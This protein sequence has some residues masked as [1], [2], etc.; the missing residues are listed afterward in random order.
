[1]FGSDN[2]LNLKY[3]T[4]EG[5][6]DYLPE[7]CMAKQ[8]IEKKIASAFASYGYKTIKTPAF[9]Y[10]DIYSQSAGDVSPQKLYKFFDA[11]GRILALRGDITTSIAR[12]MGTKY[13]DP[14]PARLC[15]VADAFRYDGA[16]SSLSSEFT[17][18]G[19]ELI[20]DGSCEADAEAIIVTINALLSAGLDEFQIDIGQ[21]EFFKGL[22]QQLGLDDE[23]FEKIR[24]MIDFKDSFSIAQV[25]EKY[26]A[27]KQIKELVCR[28]P[29]LFG[30]AEVLEEASAK[31]LNK[32]S[33]DAL[34]NLK[35]VYNIICSCG[36]EKYVSL[37]LGMLQ[38]IDYYT[39][40][41]F[42]GVTYDVG[43]SVC[44]G[45]RYDSLIAD[46]GKNMSAVGVA[47]GVN[48]VLSALVRQNKKI[49][50]PKIDAVMITKPD[51]AKAM[52]AANVLRKKGY[53]IENFYGD[54][55]DIK[56]ALSF[57][58]ERKISTVIASEG[59]ESIK[60]Y[61]LDGSEK[62][63]SLCDIKEGMTL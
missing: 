8:S 43:F 44:G 50:T 54:G 46:F 58:N 22:A 18:A 63:I 60:L 16:A 33:A 5:V 10:I 51:F 7:E 15:Y 38:S 12:V 6:M 23:D 19:I 53:M 32:R 62:T 56:E 27:D 31:N 17:Q 34:E 24:T 26:D 4:P 59:N 37:D 36:L 28:M 2:M 42:K 40:V 11:Q 3:H 13:N 55:C 21:V 29:Y 20:G 25:V 35:N 52:A 9:E 48:R 41:I 14:L 47:I 49:D 1:M 30:G 45:G 61:K 57:A 39:G